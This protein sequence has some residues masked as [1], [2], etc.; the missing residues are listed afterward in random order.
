MAGKRCPNC[1]MGK[2]G[3][4]ETFADCTGAL[5]T[6]TWCELCFKC[7]KCCTCSEQ[8]SD[9]VKRISA[10]VDAAW[11]RFHGPGKDC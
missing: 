9:V 11:V 5:I 10:N 2:P 1:F 6:L 7:N 3:Q 8:I 4:A